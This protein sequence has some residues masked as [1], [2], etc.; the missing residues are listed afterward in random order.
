MRRH[1]LTHME[2]S[3][4]SRMID[5]LERLLLINRTIGTLAIVDICIRHALGGQ[6]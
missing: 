1:K 3:C 6:I 5:I 2:Y 4:T